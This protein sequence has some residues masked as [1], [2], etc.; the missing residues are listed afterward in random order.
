MHETPRVLIDVLFVSI[1]DTGK[2]KSIVN[3]GYIGIFTKVKTKY[4][5]L[6]VC[7]RVC[8]IYGKR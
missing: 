8:G 4:L 5:Y 2:E 3:F 7:L 6:C 1:V